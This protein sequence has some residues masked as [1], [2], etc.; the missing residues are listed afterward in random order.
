MLPTNPEPRELMVVE[1]FETI[2]LENVST[3]EVALLINGYA[4]FA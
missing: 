2:P 3:D 1:P 4:K